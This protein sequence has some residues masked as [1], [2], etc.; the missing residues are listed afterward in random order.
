VNVAERIAAAAEPRV[1]DFEGRGLVA[2]ANL[3][4]RTRTHWTADELVLAEFP[5][6]RWAVPGLVP[7]GLTV[8]AAPPKA[9]KSW[10]TLQL[11]LAVAAGGRA[12][13]KVP[14]ASG[15]ALLLALEDTPRRLQQRLRML[16]EGGP[17]PRRL[18]ISTVARPLGQTVEDLRGWL[19]RHPD[20]RLVVVDV[21]A[22]LRGPADDRSSAY[23]RDYA[24][25]ASLKRVADEAQV[26]M[27]VVHHVRKMGSEDY[28]AT[29]SGTYGL[30]GA[31][32]AVAV[33]QRAR[34]SGEAVL[35][36]TGRDVE[37]SEHA[38]RFEPRAGAWVLLDEAPAELALTD[39][40]R[41]VLATIDQ[42]GSVTPKS[43]ADS[44]ADPPP[45]AGGR[46]GRDQRAGRLR[47]TRRP[48]VTHVTTVTAA[49]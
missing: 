30:I 48:P 7:E 24:S 1:G 44:Q 31:A 22:R 20:A 18:A 39:E 43:L 26:A 3:D 23:D 25:I 38:L 42:Y 33:L 32:D 6:P 29:V 4:T 47:E 17:A 13:G 45:H 40:R 49:E 2:L 16:L 19:E 28:A 35:K 15:D 8:L 10:L 36:I 41:Q 5:E 27:V 46:T 14:V 21:L 11:A 9:G 37:E 12:L 34:S